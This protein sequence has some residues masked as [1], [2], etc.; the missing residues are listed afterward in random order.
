MYKSTLSD[1]RER[2]ISVFWVDGDLVLTSL[3]KGDNKSVN[4][5]SSVEVKY[6]AS[7]HKGYFKKKILVDGS[8]YSEKEIYYK[9]L[10]KKTSLQYL[11][12]LH[13]HPAHHTIDKDIYGFF[14]SVDIQTF[15]NSDAIITG[16]ITDKL[17]I[18][19]KTSD[20]KNILLQ[21][22]E[23]TKESLTQRLF[24]ATYE[25]DFHESLQRFFPQLSGN[26]T[27]V[28]Q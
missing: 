23:I 6:E 25:G 15:I 5:R 9:N 7:T 21:D 28:N 16:L 2:A 12:N 14:S 10:P 11:F 20:T 3:I 22:S 17:W 26:N 19:I 4:T 24:L 18:L 1:E 13:T 8:I 27:S